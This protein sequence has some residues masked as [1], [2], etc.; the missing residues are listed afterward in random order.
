MAYYVPVTWATAA[1][2]H[3]VEVEVWH[4]GVC[5]GGSESNALGGVIGK[6]MA[7]ISRYSR[8]C[9]ACFTFMALSGYLLRVF[10]AADL[11]REL[12]ML[13]E[14]SISEVK[15]EGW[16]D[17][18]RLSSLSHLVLVGRVHCSQWL[19]YSHHSLYYEH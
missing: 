7:S 19:L 3:R 10:R 6:G 14:C 12:D 9:L 17:L 11:Y 1:P 16:T 2:A 15:Q 13:A 5:L 18:G 8:P 4:V